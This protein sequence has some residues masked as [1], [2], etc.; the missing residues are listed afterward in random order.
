MPSLDDA[1]TSLARPALFT[2]SWL[3]LFGAVSGLVCVWLVARQHVWNWPIGLTNNA[4]FFVLFWR[5]KLYADALLQI[6]FAALSIYGWWRWTRHGTQPEA[7]IRTTTR[8]EWLLLTLLS[9]LATVAVAAL[10]AS[11]SDSPAPLWDA[12]VLTLSLAA[13]YGQ[14]Q[15]LLESWYVWIVV[16]LLSIPLYVSRSLHLTALVYVVFLV[17]C[18]IGL[19]DWKRALERRTESV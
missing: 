18:L 13:T 4:L 7:R 16:D 19:R 9:V 2:M 3:E 14:A 15:K 11:Q 17:L 10:L 12:S 5:G 1:L 6:A 8:R